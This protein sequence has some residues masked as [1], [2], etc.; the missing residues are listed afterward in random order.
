MVKVQK[1]MTIHQIMNL[2]F[3]QNMIVK[4]LNIKIQIEHGSILVL[5]HQ[6]LVH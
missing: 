5:K 4:E 3:G 1:Q 2:I 6:Q